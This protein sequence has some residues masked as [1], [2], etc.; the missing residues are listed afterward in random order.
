MFIIPKFSD[1]NQRV[2]EDKSAVLR[3]LMYEKPKSYFLN[4]YKNIVEHKKCF[5]SEYGSTVVGEV[6]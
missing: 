3:G 6:T 1:I 5:W 2:T 4:K